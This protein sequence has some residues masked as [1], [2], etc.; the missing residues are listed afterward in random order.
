M[1]NKIIALILIQP[2]ISGASAPE[3]LSPIRYDL[4]GMPFVDLAINGRIHS[5]QIDTG[6]NEGLHIYDYQLNKIITSP[7]IDVLKKSESVSIDITGKKSHANKYLIK[8]IEIS[9][10]KFDNV[11]AINFIPWGYSTNDESPP[12]E[13]IGLG[14]FSEKI[15]FLDFKENSLSLIKSLPSETNRWSKYNFSLTSSGVMVNATSKG[16]KYKLVVDTGASN[17]ILFSKGKNKPL[18]AGGCSKIFPSANDSECS[19]SKIKIKDTDNY[20]RSTY[21]IVVDV[22]DESNQLDFDGLIGMDIL[23]GHKVIFDMPSRNLYISRY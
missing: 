15:L 13:V 17:S 22:D 10:V 16:N 2:S 14:L 19:V 7:D 20:Q 11:E 9:G 5:M 3:V 8:T 6:S 12:S 4:H 1:R 21:A 18:I 23:K